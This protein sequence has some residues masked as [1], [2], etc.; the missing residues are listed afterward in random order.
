MFFRSHEGVGGDQRRF[1]LCHKNVNALLRR[2]F[3]R[4]AKIVL[5]HHRIRF[6][7]SKMGERK[8][9]SIQYIYNNKIATSEPMTSVISLTHIKQ[10]GIIKIRIENWDCGC[11]KYKL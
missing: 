5:I 4:A 10:E 3:D 1:D 11:R 9:H 7:G 6:W 2:I 8:Y